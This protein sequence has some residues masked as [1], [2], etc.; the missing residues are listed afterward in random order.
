MKSEYSKSI[1]WAIFN[2]TI[3][4]GNSLQKHVYKSRQP[5]KE[6]VSGE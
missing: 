4:Y 2:R 5:W 3:T 1:V 6:L